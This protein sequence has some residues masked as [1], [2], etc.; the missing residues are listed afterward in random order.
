MSLPPKLILNSFLLLIIRSPK[1]NT[2]PSVKDKVQILYEEEKRDDDG[3]VFRD[4]SV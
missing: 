3:G 1:I 2:L 4:R